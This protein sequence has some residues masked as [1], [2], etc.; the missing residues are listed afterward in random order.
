MIR[1]PK[2]INQSI[3]HSAVMLSNPATA[4]LLALVLP[5]F[6]RCM[7]WHA[8]VH[9]CPA[10]QRHYADDD[11]NLVEKYGHRLLRISSRK[12]CVVPRTRNFITHQELSCCRS[13]NLHVKQSHVLLTTT[14]CDRPVKILALLFFCPLVLHSQGLRN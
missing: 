11:N 8:M 5:M 2:S 10:K 13:A 4:L 6:L 12:A 14:I 3:N 7:K 1:S 9:C